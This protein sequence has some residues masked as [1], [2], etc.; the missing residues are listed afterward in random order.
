MQ[1]T[2]I[3][4]A[5]M[6]W[7]EAEGEP[8][9]GKIAVAQVVLNRYRLANRPSHQVTWWGKTLEEIITHPHQ[10]RGLARVRNLNENPPLDC[11]TIA[12]I[13]IADY[14]HPLVDTATHFTQVDYDLFK[15]SSSYTFVRIIGNHAFYRENYL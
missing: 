6:I 4:L 14:L 13:A 12:E 8:L 3:K 1:Q 10:F 2:T 7:G 11:L 5:W 9:E 15:G